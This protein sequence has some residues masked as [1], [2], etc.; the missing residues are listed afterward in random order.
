[1]ATALPT[2][3]K[4]LNGTQFIWVGSAYTLSTTAFLPLSGALAEVKPKILIPLRLL[5]QLMSKAFGRRPVMLVLLGMFALG[6]A[7]CG[8]A[9]D[10]NFLIAGRGNGTVLSYQA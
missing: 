7:L 4:E 5:T 3:I 1:M 8:A 10:L 2:I 9:K 6:S